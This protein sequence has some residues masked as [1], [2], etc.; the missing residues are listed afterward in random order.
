MLLG[1]VTGMQTRYHRIQFFAVAVC[2]IGVA[3]TILADYWR[4]QAAKRQQ[5]EAERLARLLAAARR[6]S[7]SGHHLEE[8]QQ[9]SSGSTDPSPAGTGSAGASDQQQ[10]P[11][12]VFT[13]GDIVLGDFLVLL[14]AILYSASNRLQEWILSKSEET[15]VEH[16]NRTT[17]REAR[18]R[19]GGQ[20]DSRGTELVEQP[21][22]PSQSPS[23]PVLMQQETSA[24][25]PFS[26]F[27]SAKIDDLEVVVV[28]PEKDHK[29]KNQEQQQMKKDLAQLQLYRTL[30]ILG[31]IGVFFGAIQFF[32]VGEF[33]VFRQLLQTPKKGLRCLR[34]WLLVLGYECSMFGLY[35]TCSF[36]LQR[37][38]TVAFNL[39]T[40][41]SN[42]YILLY[43][44]I[45][46]ARVNSL[47][48]LGFSITVGG[49]ILY[50][51]F[52]GVEQGVKIIGEGDVDDEVGK[53]ES[54]EALQEQDS[55]YEQER[56]D[57][58]V[59][60]RAYNYLQND[61]DLELGPPD[62]A[63][64]EKLDAGR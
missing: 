43:H 22:A 58:H 35:T 23:S 4:M 36:F 32:A 54:S 59:E 33:H 49:I 6:T 30:F 24:L 21:L 62:Q 45:C 5:D 27:S 29:L 50:T 44:Q 1:W 20:A 17:E 19:R 38:N 57:D 48:Y 51:L 42:V 15:D 64:E 46:G 2:G 26:S 61:R 18:G 13:I 47:F 63:Q 53:K 31:A 60:K 14:S 16:M 55:T 39:C 12:S 40:L 28:T 7:V 9:S 56:K 3:L 52:E 37:C 10:P 25:P 11:D 8:H 41:T 34:T